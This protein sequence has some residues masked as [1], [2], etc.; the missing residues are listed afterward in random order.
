MA[1]GKTAKR[2]YLAARARSDSARGEK[3]SGKPVTAIRVDRDGLVRCRVCWCTEREACNP[4]CGWF[5]EDLCTSCALAAEAITSWMERARR[6]NI[7]A[8]LREVGR[9]I[10]C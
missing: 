3:A 2:D 6:A 5:E 4:P 10:T 8:L 7:S 9:R 1:A